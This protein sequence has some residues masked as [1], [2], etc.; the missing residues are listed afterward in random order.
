[1]T[2]DIE[3]REQKADPTD[4]FGQVA[5]LVSAGVAILSVLI[6]VV[7]AVI[8]SVGLVAVTVT[9]MDAKEE[10]RDHNLPLIKQKEALPDYEVAVNLTDGQKILLGTKTNTSA[11]DGLTWRLS[12]PISVGEIAGIRLLDQD[13]LVSDEITEV[14][15]T[16]DSVKDGNYRLDFKTE[17]SLSVGVGSFFRTPIGK[18]VTGAFTIA[19]VALVLSLFR[20][21]RIRSQETGIVQEVLS[22]GE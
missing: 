5:K 18:A 9:A 11:V 12:D 4:T 21:G 17:R 13:K 22:L 8:R 14:Q 7:L 15:L 20:T 1:M 3:N 16:G 19:I 2:S 10:P 6:C